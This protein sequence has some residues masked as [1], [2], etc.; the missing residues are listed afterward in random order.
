MLFII[1]LTIMSTIVRQ[2]YEIHVIKRTSA[3]M[4]PGKK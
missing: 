4:G 2:N 3:L 1:N